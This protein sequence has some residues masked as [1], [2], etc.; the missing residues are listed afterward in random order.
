MKFRLLLLPLV[1]LFIFSLAGNPLLGASYYV[2]PSGAG[3]SCTLSAPC[4]LTTGLGKPGPG[5]EVVLLDGIYK[6]TLYIRRGG[7]STAPVVVRALNTHKAIIQNPSGPLGRVWANYVTVRGLV[8]DGMKTGGN[9]GA[10]RVGAG[11]EVTL[12]APVHHVILE[13]IWVKNTRAA[14]ISIT[15]GENNIVVRDSV[16]E[17]TGH[18]EFWGEAFYLGSKYN[19]DQTVYNIEIYR[20]EAR[21]FTENA[22]ETKRYSRNVTVRNN[23][24]HHQVLF[25]DYGGDPAE[26]NDGTI[27]LDGHSHTVYNNILHSNKCGMAVFVV[28]PEANIKVYNNIVY[29]GISPGT[30]AVRMKDWSKSFP[31]G[32]YPPSQVYNNTFYKLV[33]HSVGSLNSSILIVRNNL[34]IDLSGNL[35]ASQTTSSLFMNSA[36][37]DFRLVSGCAAIDRA[38]SSPFT[39]T[40]FDGRGTTGSYRDFGAYEYFTAG[41][42]RA[43]SGL[44]VVNASND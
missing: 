42:P 2:S 15:T 27:T 34:G 37:G 24:F 43:P 35:S 36:A 7:T 40:D 29:N 16:I 21:G 11:D 33:N 44:K 31:T 14:G 39:S 12:P 17:S 41:P 18:Q 8:F 28:E 10:V 19:A 3:T 13:K 5:D 22:L 1:V 25:K 30:Y 6:G 4:S 26:G 38:S 20:N 23:I 9:R 32:K